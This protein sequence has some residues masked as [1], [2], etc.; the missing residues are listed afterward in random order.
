[1][2]L[3]S[4]VFLMLALPASAQ[5][6]ARARLDAACAARDARACTEL[7]L[8][9]ASGHDGSLGNREPD[10]R[11]AVPYFQRGCARGHAEGCERLGELFERG[12]GRA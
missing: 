2:T 9:L 10:A 1:M 6:P 8:M 11:A 7:G 4:G 3:L 12:D 5:T